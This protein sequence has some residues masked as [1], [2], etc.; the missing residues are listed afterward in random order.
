MITF[1]RPPLSEHRRSAVR[2]AFLVLLVVLVVVSGLPVMVGGMGME[3]CP[4]C[5][6]ATLACSVSCAPL[7][8]AILV[9]VTALFSFVVVAPRRRHGLEFAWSIDPPPRV[10]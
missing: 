2:T 4:D 3:P 6:P 5:G 9:A 1:G 10:A 8:T 7:S